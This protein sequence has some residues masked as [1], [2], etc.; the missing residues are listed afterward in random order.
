LVKTGKYQDMY[1]RKI[2][3]DWDRSRQ[4]Y[5]EVTDVQVHCT[6]LS[7]LSFGKP[8]FQNNSSKYCPAFILLYFYSKA[9][10]VWTYE[11]GKEITK[12]TRSHIVIWRNGDQSKY[13]FLNDWI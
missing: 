6:F 9:E 11:D 2:A 7:C 13:L 4:Y 8:L 12:V 1:A 5:V 10:L 3:Y